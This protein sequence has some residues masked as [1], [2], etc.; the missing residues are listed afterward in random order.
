MGLT[1][2]IDFGSTYTKLV[3]ID[4]NRV[5]LLGV[6]QAA[7]TV[8]TD[9]TM[10]LRIAM[11]KMQTSLGVA[12]LDIDR[13]L[14]C[15]SAAG[16]LRMVAIGLVRQLTTKAAEEAALGAGA[17][18]IGTYS[19]G[20]SE[21]DIKCIEQTVPDI[22][23][24]TG[25][26]D[27]GN[28]KFIIH[29]AEVLAASEWNG[30]VVIAGNKRAASKAQ[31]ILQAADKYAIVVDNVLPELDKLNVE[32]A[33]DT[34][35]EIFMQRIT[36]SKG[37]DKAQ[38]FVG[39][40]IMPTPM[41]VLQGARLLAEGAGEEPGL[42]DLIVVDVG[43]A[44]TDVHSIADGSP[45]RQGVIVKGLPEPYAK[46]TVEGDLGIRYNAKV[47]LK[48]AG[49]KQVIERITHTKGSMTQQPNLNAAV[50]FLSSNVE[51][52]PRNEAESCIDI[53]LASTAVDIA[54][55]RHAGS[56]EEV[57]FTSGKARIQYGKDLTK[58]GSVI[59][60][61]GIFAYGQDPLCVLKAAGFDSTH[62]ESLKPLEPKFYIDQRYIL[63]A[64][65]LVSQVAPIEALKVMKK[66][67]KAI[68][69]T[70]A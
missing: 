62:P 28:E 41:A 1:L 30:P 25:G 60:T 12:N 39:E 31:S 18:I 43:G 17:K 49:E 59:G 6:T 58:T 40:I 48:V 34:I 32:P 63:Y 27:G 22:I 15:S 14:A 8:D 5:E 11:E 7:S 33:R 55:R 24:L 4:I 68:K 70:T 67:L 13:I 16:G 61:G 37:L 3:A 57:Y 26:T 2:A 21:H 44:T 50:E 47:I 54:M 20:L 56:I 51:T 35:R 46:R 69:D 45:T 23:L 42:G 65:G 52:V 38:S 9:I 29:D 66:H 19:Y 53:G 64:V 10:G 36:H